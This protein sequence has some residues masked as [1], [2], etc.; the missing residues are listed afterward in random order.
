MFTAIEFSSFSDFLLILGLQGLSKS[1]LDSI[2]NSDPTHMLCQQELKQLKDEFELYKS[3]TSMLNKNK[4]A[5]DLTAQLENLEKLK[6]RNAKVEKR[7]LDIQ[8]R[9]KEKENEM[10]NRIVELEKELKDSV[11]RL[12][13]EQENQELLYKHKLAELEKQVLKQRERTIE[14]LAEK[15]S[16]INSLRT[17][18]PN[19]SPSGVGIKTFSYPRRYMEPQDSG[20]EMDDGLPEETN[21]AVYQLI[22]R[23]NSVR[24][25]FYVQSY[26]L[27]LSEAHLVLILD[28]L[29]KKL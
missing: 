4:P 10:S 26:T 16:E 9:N 22:T 17:R 27:D 24:N 6:I 28:K 19:A 14:L 7:L 1:E 8:E 18:S 5:K 25:L 2:L 13:K 3:K 11:E 23:Q 29:S 20:R 12:T 21:E 15:D